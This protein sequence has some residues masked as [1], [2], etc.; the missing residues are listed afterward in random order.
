[1]KDDDLA[2]EEKYDS[3]IEVFGEKKT[4]SNIQRIELWDNE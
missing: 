3:N 2:N 1:M 4:N